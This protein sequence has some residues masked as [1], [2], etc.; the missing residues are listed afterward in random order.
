MVRIDRLLMID[1]T[2]FDAAMWKDR[3]IRG[4]LTAWG[5]AHHREYTE[6]PIT[7]GQIRALRPAR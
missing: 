6:L 2:R 7:Y 3:A 1:L 4:R 5:R